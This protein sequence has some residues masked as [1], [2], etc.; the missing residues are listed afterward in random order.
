MQADSFKLADDPRVTRVG[1]WLR[2]TSLD[3]ITQLFNV[4]K[5]E[6][7]LVGPRPALDWE[8]EAFEPRYRRRTD[9]LPGLT[10]LWQVSGRSPLPPPPLPHPTPHNL[11][12]PP[13]SPPPH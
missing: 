3:E 1:K 6:M 2:A 12:P 9:V 4:V 8:H 10:G 13:T 5:G 7:A 11:H